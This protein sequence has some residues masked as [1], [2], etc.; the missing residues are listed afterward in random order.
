MAHFD[1]V[2]EEVAEP[3]RDGLV[4]LHEPE[5]IRKA[6]RLLV[7]WSPDRSVSRRRWK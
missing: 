4:E 6:L 2:I 7:R 1:R 3:Q 5:R